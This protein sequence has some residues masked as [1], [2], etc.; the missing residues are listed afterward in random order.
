MKNYECETDGLSELFIK[1]A[2]TRR[3]KAGLPGRYEV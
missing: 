2:E 1:T 3:K